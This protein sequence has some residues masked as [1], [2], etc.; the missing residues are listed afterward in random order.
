[1]PAHATA[2]DTLPF[3]AT[4]P[5]QAYPALRAFLINFGVPTKEHGRYKPI[6]WAGQIWITDRL[7][8]R[9][10]LVKDA[11]GPDSVDGFAFD[12]IFEGW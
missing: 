9:L 12:L 11:T 3:K 4:D 10:W 1:M 7:K 5:R 2:V 6:F 8:D